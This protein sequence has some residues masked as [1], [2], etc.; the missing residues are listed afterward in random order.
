MVR[1]LLNT[2][3]LLFEVSISAQV[4]VCDPVFVTEG[5]PVT[6]TFDAAQG[7]AGLKN[8]AE[9]WYVHTGVI[10]DKSSSDTD[11]KYTKTPWPTG[12][13]LNEANTTANKLIKIGNNKANLLID[14]IRSYYGVPSGE[15]ILK[16]CFVFRN[17]TGTVEGKDTGGKDIYVNVYEP[18]VS[19]TF[20][21]P[22]NNAVLIQDTTINISITAS[23]A[24]TVRLLVDDN[25][26]ASG[27]N[28]TN[29]EV[30][31]QFGNNEKYI[32]V[33]KAGTG[34][35]ISTDTV[36]VYIRPPV[37]NENRPENIG[38]GIHYVDN[39]TVSLCLYAPNKQFVY[40][41]GDFN[42]W[43]INNQ[44]LMNKDGDY[45]W[46]TIQGLTE[47]TE[48]AYQYLV[49]GHLLIA[50]PY[51]DKILDP[52]NDQYIPQTVYPDLKPYPAGKTEGIVS[53]FQTGQTSYS[54]KI[55]GFEP[56]EK[57]KLIIYEI[58]VRDF[59]ENHDFKGVEEKLDY[60]QSLGVNAIELMPVNEFEGN[61]SWGY[62]PSFYFAVD[63]YYGSKNDFKALVDACHKK[64]IA[65]IMDMVLNHSYGQCPL[66]RLYWDEINQRPSSD[67]LWYNITSP[68][69]DFE[70]G[71]DFNHESGQTQQLVDSICSY[72]MKEYQIDGFRFDFTKGFTNTPGNGMAYDQS[73][74]RILKRMTQEIYN[75]KSDAIVIF[76]H[77]TD[78]QEEIELADADILLWGNMNYNYCEG[79]MA[80]TE[81]NQT[82][83]SWGI[84][85]KRGFHQPYLIN[86]M[87]S[88]DEERM[89]YKAKTYGKEWGTYNTKDE[90]TALERA[91]LSACFYIPLPGPKM[92]WQ[93]G[94]LGYD[95]SIN[96]CEDGTVA[97]CRLSPKPIRWDYYD[98]DD[99]RKLYDKYSI[100][101]ELKSTYPVFS[102]SDF[103][104]SLQ[105]ALK[106][107]VW[108]TSDMNA[109]LVGNFDVVES[110]V[111]IE[112]PH[113]GTWYDIF[114]GKAEEIS[115][116]SFTTTLQ[117]GEYRFYTD[118]QTYSDIDDTEYLRKIVIYPNPAND[119]IR[120]NTSSQIHSVGVYSVGG[121][122]MMRME[123]QDYL[124][125]TGLP[126]GFY[127]L[128]VIDEKGESIHKFTKK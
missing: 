2:L 16:L 27:E 77:L 105:G 57:E 73:R 118:K 17:P 25:E 76:E 79:I 78:N 47:G 117:P 86:Y 108:K 21:N 59:T 29:L 52:W 70:W 91:A 20:T 22:V 127:I 39:Q 103:S 119:Y 121:H 69:T 122:Q 24:T 37:N 33:A 120:I 15:K 104:Y 42:D 13:N 23:T 80:Y 106:S 28:I 114:T 75:R 125:V 11:W 96:T 56:V 55:S 68:N 51:T 111:I 116:T 31:Y 112:I 98:Q 109:F 85:S 19:V 7:S 93:F 12:T 46:L 89:L 40:V 53:V 74:I 128:R 6:V 26:I 67:N 34:T 72:W 63:K 36:G 83:L 92:I 82:D 61:D 38:A 110:P 99:R 87:E 45:W 84:Y 49:D 32:L 64:G 60:L 5:Q 90:K 44:F 126:R 58:L 48:Y 115:S 43:Q 41:K 3:L 102:T 65:V 50:D 14:E 35:D 71:Y 100:L 4:V 88:H 9:D 81:N 123:N 107:F 1:H 66:V 8:N 30:P 97:D 95:Y 101:N 113:S 10:T 18:G 124:N 94:E 54:W 62:N